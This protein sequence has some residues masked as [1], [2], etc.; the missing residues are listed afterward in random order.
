MDGMVAS[1]VP[2]WLMQV[3]RLDSRRSTELYESLSLQLEPSLNK[4]KNEPQCQQVSEDCVSSKY[5]WSA[6]LSLDVGTWILIVVVSHDQPCSSETGSPNSKWI[7]TPQKLTGSL[8]KIE[9]GPNIPPAKAK[10]PSNQ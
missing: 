6:R 7:W 9:S 8:P 1:S 4:S 5:K 10:Q 3:H 2:S